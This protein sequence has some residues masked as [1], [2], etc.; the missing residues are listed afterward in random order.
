MNRQDIYRQDYL[1]T[2]N[3]NDCLEKGKSFCTKVRNYPDLRHLEHIIKLQLPEVELFL[4]EDITLPQN[5]TQRMNIDP[6]EESLCKSR[7]KIIYP[8][9]GETTSSNWSF[10]LNNQNYKQ[11]VRIEECEYD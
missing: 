1:Y 5:I 11:G 3:V 9:A 6:Y 2:V 10:I 7:E 8:E 4:S